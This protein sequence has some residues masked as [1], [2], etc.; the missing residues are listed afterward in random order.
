MCFP[1]G[2]QTD[3]A[4]LCNPADPTSVGDKFA[5]HGLCCTAFSMPLLGLFTWYFCGMEGE[6]S[7]RVFPYPF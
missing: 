1:L 3:S 4:A 2:K 7:A 5:E 6:H